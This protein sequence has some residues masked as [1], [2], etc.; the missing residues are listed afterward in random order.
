M[1]PIKDDNGI[2]RVGGRLKNATCP[3]EMKVPIIL[4]R[5]CRLTELLML[6][7]HETTKHGHVQVMM[8]YLRQRYWIPRLRYELRR[9]VSRCVTCKR[10]DHPMGTQLM[11]DLPFDRVNLC[12]PFLHTGIDYAGPIEIK[13]SLHP[14]ASKRK[15]WIAVFVCLMSR[16][17]HLDIVLD[18]TSAEFLNCFKR[19]VGRRGRCETMYSDNATTFVGASKELKA[20]LKI[21]YTEETL[22]KI[23]S[24]GTEWRFM[25]AGAPHQGGI[26]EAS[27]KVTKHHL[28]RVIGGQCWTYAQYNT[29]LIEIE[30]VLNS[31]PLYEL[32][33]DPNDTQALTPGH[34]LFGEA[35]KV[36]ARMDPP[37]KTKYSIKRI[38]NEA[39]NMRDNFWKRYLVEYLPTLQ[40]RK[41][42]VTENRD[43]KIGQLA[44]IKDEN[45]SPAH[46]LMGRIVE[47]IPS[48][49]GLV[50]S[51]KL[52]TVSGHLSR[53]VQKICILPVDSE[54]ISGEYSN[55]SN[56]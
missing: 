50:R 26:Y 56:D 34:F 53:P 11:G 7:T 47:L 39:Q 32:T 48:K 13:D 25:T 29:L 51:V 19:F 41:K 44:V 3:Y 1:R 20:A 31:R 2:L 33:D 28:R 35:V 12:K 52:K 15:V 55:T 30:A 21:W 6:E 18:L 49:D 37:P 54:G 4:P 10:Y 42:W 5:K 17:I 22:K 24:F 23:S 43:Y 45:L 46:W 36:P 16:A 27:V 14:R 9:F 40:T 38:W 8:Q